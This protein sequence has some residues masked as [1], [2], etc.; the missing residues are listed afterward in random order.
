MTEGAVISRRWTVHP[1]HPQTKR[2]FNDW[3]DEKTRFQRP[4]R[5]TA[6]LGVLNNQ[7]AIL[8]IGAGGDSTGKYRLLS[9]RGPEKGRTR[10]KAQDRNGFGELVTLVVLKDLQCRQRFCG[11]C[12]QLF[13]FPHEKPLSLMGDDGV[14][15]KGRAR[16]EV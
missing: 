5:Q 12:H 9:G 16:C 8:L 3:P 1:S 13:L 15:C 4:L 7:P 14:M 11:E 10:E 2:T 6:G